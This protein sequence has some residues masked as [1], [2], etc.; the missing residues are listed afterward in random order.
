MITTHPELSYPVVKLSQF[1]K[2]PAVIH[3][4]SVYSIFQYLSGTLNDRLMYTRPN[5][6]TWAP[7]VKHTPL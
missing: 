5:P 6:M 2:N 4:D 3:Y 1:V 7:V